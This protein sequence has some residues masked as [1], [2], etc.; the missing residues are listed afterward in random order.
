[1]NVKIL[2][3]VKKDLLEGKNTYTEKGYLLYDAIQ[4]TPGKTIK[5]EFLNTGKT[6]ASME[7]DTYLNEGDTII[8][9]LGT[10]NKLRLTI[11]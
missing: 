11:S 2:E 7:I 10:I 8:L 6:L 4:F 9:N 1:M 5:V 3:I